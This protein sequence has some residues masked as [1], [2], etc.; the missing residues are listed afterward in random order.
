MQ[1]SLLTLAIRESDYRTLG[2][3][4]RGTIADTIELTLYER[5]LSILVN[6]LEEILDFI[7]FPNKSVV[8][9]FLS[10]DELIAMAI[11]RTRPK[12]CA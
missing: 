3:L 4:F 5:I 12:P 10:Q 6:L 1:Y 7:G 11:K 9:K 2:G 8:E